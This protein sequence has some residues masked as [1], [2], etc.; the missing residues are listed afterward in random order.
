M[1]LRDFLKDI[2][3]LIILEPK[4]E[5]IHFVVVKDHARMNPEDLNIKLDART[6]LIAEA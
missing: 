4:S 3:V 2:A 6:L 1:I 5:Y